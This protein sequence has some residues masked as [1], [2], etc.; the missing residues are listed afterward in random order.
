MR[1]AYDHAVDLFEEWFRGRDVQR[2]R[3][4][5]ISELATMSIN[6]ITYLYLLFAYA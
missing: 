2:L 1:A 3:R 4:L 5:N 6:I